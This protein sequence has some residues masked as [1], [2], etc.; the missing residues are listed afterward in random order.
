MKSSNQSLSILIWVNKSRAV[1]NYA[2]LYAR[3]TVNQKRANISLQKKVNIQTW[4]SNKSKVRG[5]SQEARIINSHIED[6]KNELFETYKEL[7][8]EGKLITSQRIKNR[9]LGLDKK[10]HALKELFQLYNSTVEKKIKKDTLDSYKTSQNYILEYLLKNY[11]TEDI[12]LK[13]L[14]FGFVVG[15]EKFLREYIPENNQSFIGHNTAMK[16]IQRLKKVI[17][18]AVDLEWLERNP[19]IKFKLSFE[20]K[21]RTY[22]TQTELQSVEELQISITRL[23]QVKDVFLFS[24]Y[25]GIAYVD[26]M[27][28]SPG[29][30]VMGIDGNLWID[31]SRQKTKIGFKLPLL[32]LAKQMVEKY[33]THPKSIA[34]NKLFPKISNQKLNAYLKEIA[35]LCNIKKNLT[36]HMARHTFATTVTLTNGVPVETVSKML[37][38]KKIATTQIYSKVIDVKIQKDMEE[39]KGKLKSIS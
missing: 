30:L 21:Q 23:E 32:P 6:V 26:I 25:T 33:S 39:L 31:T 22:L 4:D 38:H 13:E 37:G 2:K 15:F 19:F 35:D 7:K 1:D 5:N 11:K 10:E 28:L 24:C 9:Y 16:H 20:Q 14:D 3:L 8:S 17:Q 27:N 29:N 36:F 12:N 18:F 34:N